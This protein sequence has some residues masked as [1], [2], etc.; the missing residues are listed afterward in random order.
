MG[1]ERKRGKL[2]ELNRLLRG[3]TD[4]TFI[5][6]DGDRRGAR[7]TC[8]T[9]SRSMPI[10][11]CRA[12]RCA[13][14]VGKMAHP[15]NRPRFDPPTR[16]RRRGLWRPAAARHAVAAG[17]ARR[18]AVPARLLQ[19][20]RH[21][22]L[23]RRGLRRLSGPVRRRLLH[24]QGHLRRRCLRGGARRPRAREHAAQPRP[25]RGHVRARRPGVRR[26]GGRGISR[27]ATTSPRARQHRWARGDWQLLPW[28]LGLATA[29][30]GA[31]SGGASRASA[32]GRCSTICGARCRRR[33]ASLALLAGWTL[34]L[35]RRAGLDGLRPGRRSRCRRCCRSLGAVAAAPRRHHA[36]Q[37]LRARS[38]R[39]SCS[40][41]RADRACSSRSSRIRPG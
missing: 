15:L 31:Q 7:R 29:M 2:H 21:R 35:P 6:V 28:M 11:G 36:A 16:P 27:R 34:P 22:S 18:L 32:A 3:A 17:R 19:H 40:A 4:T 39:I 24:R 1:W 23:R 41:L 8:A 9:S 37:P 25:V 10:R 20:Q 33:P 13:R 30:R 14:L 26:R 38:A 5:A 12:T